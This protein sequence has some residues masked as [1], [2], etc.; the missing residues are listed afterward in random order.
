MEKKQIE[1]GNGFFKS[2][3]PETENLYEFGKIKNGL[4]D[5]KWEFYFPSG[6]IFIESN[7]SEGKLNGI[8]K[9]YFE[10]ENVYAQGNLKNNKRD[11]EWKW[12]HENGNLAST[13]FFEDGLKNGKQLFYSEFGDLKKE[14]IYEKGKLIEE[15]L[16]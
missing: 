16:L 15:K 5:D 6:S 2:F 13:A 10:T 11:G 3:Y 14:E 8:Q 12:Y 4:R 1:N 9:T 7:Y